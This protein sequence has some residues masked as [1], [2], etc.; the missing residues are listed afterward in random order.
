MHCFCFENWYESTLLTMAALTATSE[1]TRSTEMAQRD[2]QRLE[3]AESGQKEPNVQKFKNSMDAEPTT[4]PVKAS[5]AVLPRIISIHKRKISLMHQCTEFCRRFIY[6]N[7]IS[8][9]RP[10]ST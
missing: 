3:T 1:A 4:V 6:K 10:C 5:A 2:N 7:G 8:N 9:G